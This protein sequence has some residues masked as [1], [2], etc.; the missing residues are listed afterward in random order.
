MKKVV[1]ILC[2]LLIGC[3]S[4]ASA[5]TDDN[6]WLDDN[7]TY[8]EFVTESNALCIFVSRRYGEGVAL[9]CDFSK[10]DW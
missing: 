3:T 9:Q 4:S 2:L 5:V 7:Y 8:M 10:A 6:H 1:F